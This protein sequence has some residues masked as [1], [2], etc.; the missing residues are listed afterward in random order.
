MNQALGTGQSAGSTESA[1]REDT[2]IPRWASLDSQEPA[3]RMAKATS[4]VVAVTGVPIKKKRGVESA[5]P[6]PSP[7]ADQSMNPIPRVGVSS[8]VG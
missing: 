1:P 6:R 2:G 5:C 3:I 8:H 4:T 7:S